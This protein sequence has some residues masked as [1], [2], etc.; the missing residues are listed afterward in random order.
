M[1]LILFTYKAHPN[2]FLVL[3]AN[4]DEFYARPTLGADFWEDAPHILAGRDLKAGGTWLGVD[5]FGRF[6]AVSNYRDPGSNKTNALSRGHLVSN[7]L[8]G[9]QTPADY[10]DNLRLR[11][12]EYN[13]FNLLVG[14]RSE[15]W[16]YSNRI[17]TGR[18][19][20]PGV[21]G[22]S[23]HLLDTPWPKV[24]RGKKRLGELL[25][26]NSTVDPE[27]IL[28]ILSDCTIAD[29]ADLPDTG[30]GLTM[31]RMLSPIFIVSPHYG[32]RSSSVLLIDRDEQ[33]TFVERSFDARPPQTIYYQFKI[34]SER[35][36]DPSPVDT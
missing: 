10:V 22:A 2:Y 35:L 14:D 19:L 32:T 31:E 16:Y 29:D 30:V 11:G 4:R 5:R 26:Q 13:G 9:Q 1:C 34:A 8:R 33:V 17:N 3:A 36:G 27:A 24:Q 6:A 28:E 25:A 12:Q 15:L 20:E 18:L 7:F 21:H 23:N